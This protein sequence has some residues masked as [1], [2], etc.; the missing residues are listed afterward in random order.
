MAVGGAEG[1][2]HAPEVGL[3]SA[4][5]NNFRLVEPNS[6]GVLT[7]RILTLFNPEEANAAAVAKVSR[8]LA[9]V[10]GLVVA[11]NALGQEGEDA[12]LTIGA[13]GLD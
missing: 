6:K 8:K 4:E 12:N 9:Q 11:V 5:S 1:T 10:V 3:T 7:V 13:D 2:I